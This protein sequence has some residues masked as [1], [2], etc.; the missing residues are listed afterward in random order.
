MRLLH[1]VNNLDPATGGPPVV[2]ISLAAA[3]AA[4]GHD[5]HLVAYEAGESARLIAETPHARQVNFH[6]LP[7]STGVE[8]VTANRAIRLITDLLTLT[9]FDVAH[10]H[11][12]W[13]PLFT[14]SGQILRKHGVPYVMNLNGMLDPWSLQQSKAKKKI[15]LALGVRALL[16]NA[17]AIHCG[18]DD[19][20]KLIAPLD[21]RSTKI[22]LYN[23]VWP[24]PADEMPAR[25]EFYKRFPELNAEPFA[26]FLGRL[27]YKKGLDIL[28]PA[29]SQYARNHPEG[30]LALVGPEDSTFDVR[31]AIAESG[32]ADRIHLLGAVYERVAK[33]AAYQDAAC[34]VLPSRQ[35]SFPLAVLDAVSL[36]TPALISAGC[37]FPQIQRYGAGVVL[38]LE[39][40]LWAQAFESV[41]TNPSR[42]NNIGRAGAKLVEQHFTW[43]RV[44]AK[45]IGA[46]EQVLGRMQ[47][48]GG[49]AADVLG[50][51]LSAT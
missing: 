15:A 23:S 20:A 48:I 18:N 21:I 35:E 31:R 8:T 12:V 33:L 37:H 24:V 16:D 34:F 28:I 6:L 13:E 19:E 1:L 22:I 40:A 36:G 2:A 4:L 50:P 47:T 45:C 44:A 5:V 49:A 26:L 43:P 11:G 39:P 9:P 7:P 17:A 46:Y 42:A 30:R 51:R 38:P 10:M 3:Q 29:F 25:G 14:R 27:T 32:V 41:L